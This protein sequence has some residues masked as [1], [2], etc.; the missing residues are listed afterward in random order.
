MRTN[1]V[2]CLVGDK[3]SQF[4]ENNHDVLTVAEFEDFL[5]KVA[6]KELDEQ[7]VVVVGQGVSESHLASFQEAISKKGLRGMRIVVPAAEHKKKAGALTHKHK[8][9]NEMISLPQQISGNCYES[10]LILDDRCS[11]MSDHVT[12]K[13]LQ[14]MIIIEAARQMT[15]AVTEKYFMDEKDRANFSF[16]TNSLHTYFHGYIF[17]C[18]V[19]LEYTITKHSGKIGSNSK[20]DVNIKFI[21]SD[22]NK[23]EVNY[24][25]SVLNKNFIKEK[26]DVLAK[27]SVK[28][29]LGRYKN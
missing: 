19:K 20:F 10:Y 26:E 9:E 22:E 16:V 13:H 17:P 12:G 15:L 24:Q 14:G 5:K 11:E 27:N 2:M 23:A 6:M 25:F 7:L 8:N 3:L 29:Y 4:R 28:K 21:Q 1:R 18:D